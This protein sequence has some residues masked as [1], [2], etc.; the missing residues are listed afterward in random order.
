MNCA[1]NKLQRCEIA[2]QEIAKYLEQVESKILEGTNKNDTH[3]HEDNPACNAMFRKDHTTVIGR[4]LPV[5][6]LL[7]D[8][9]IKVGRDIVYSGEVCAFVDAIPEIGQKQYKEFVDQGF[10]N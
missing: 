9:F 8:S 3:H 5:N 1:S 10:K 7:E 6:P 2:G 4:L